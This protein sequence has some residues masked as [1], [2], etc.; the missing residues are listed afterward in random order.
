[1]MLGAGPNL[2]PLTSDTIILRDDHPT[3]SGLVFGATVTS[4]SDFPLA[5]F[6]LGRLA[7]LVIHPVLS[8]SSYELSG[9]DP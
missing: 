2:T 1:M 5:G 3:S 9:K 4:S 6:L 7:Q 8:R